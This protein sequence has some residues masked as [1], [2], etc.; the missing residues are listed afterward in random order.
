MLAL[1]GNEERGAVGVSCRC[2]VEE[3]LVPSPRRCDGLRCLGCVR[4]SEHAAKCH[5]MARDIEVNRAARLRR[6]DRCRRSKL[7]YRRCLA[8]EPHQHAEHLTIFTDASRSPPPDERWFVDAL[9]VLRD[10]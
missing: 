10:R 1:I 9:D 7:V 2:S 8:L 4:W 3:D 6:I 5:V